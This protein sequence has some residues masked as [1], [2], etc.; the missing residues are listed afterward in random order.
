M[1]ARSWLVGYRRADVIGAKLFTAHP[2]EDAIGPEL[3]DG[4]LLED[5]AIEPIR[6]RRP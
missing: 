6:R 1:V 5:R 4:S 2:D 3:V